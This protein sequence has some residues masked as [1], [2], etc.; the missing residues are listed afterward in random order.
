MVDDETFQ[1][2][3]ARRLA[4]VAGRAGKAG[5]RAIGELLRCS[6]PCP[7]GCEP[8]FSLAQLE[9]YTGQWDHGHGEVERYGAL[10]VAGLLRALGETC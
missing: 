1:R 9:R 3:L 5:Q 6:V 2:E 4:L 7:T 8:P 10:T